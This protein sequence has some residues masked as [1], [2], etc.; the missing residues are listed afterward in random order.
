MLSDD[1]AALKLDG[2]IGFSGAVPH[3]L[4]VV[5]SDSLPGERDWLNSYIARKIRPDR[6]AALLSVNRS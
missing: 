3:G 6:F 2:I 4:K 1:A 5:R